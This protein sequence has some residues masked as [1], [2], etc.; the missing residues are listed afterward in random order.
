MVGLLPL[1]AATSSRA[2]RREAYPRSDASASRWFLEARPELRRL[3][4]RPAQARAIAGRRL[5]SILDETKLRRV[6]ATMLDENEFLS[7]YGIRSLSRY[8]AEHPYRVPRRRARNTECRICRRSPTPACSAATRTGAG[9]S[10]CRST[11][12]IIRALL[13]Y[14]LYY[15]DDFTVECPTGSGRQM[16]LY[17]VAEE[18]ARRLASIFLQGPGRPT[19]GLRRQP[20]VPGRPA[21]ARSPAVLRVFPR[22]QRGRP[23]RQPPDRLDGDHRPQHA[24]LRQPHARAG[25]G[26]RQ[27]ILLRNPGPGA[28][29]GSGGRS[30]LTLTPSDQTQVTFPGRVRLPIN[31]VSGARNHAPC[32]ADR[33]RRTIG[34]PRIMGFDSHPRALANRLEE[35]G[36]TLLGCS[37]ESSCGAVPDHGRGRRSLRRGRLPARRAPSAGVA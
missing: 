4:P 35:R 11:P 2:T 15:G 28:N 9:R 1:C 37:I 7:P 23:R 33:P 27:T 16:T 24:S 3:H 21:L 22:R 14:Y 34:L 26:S 12:L 10:G 8:H 20:E 6:L 18:M 19:A 32:D 13:Q 29:R 25:S 36:W 17:Q 30:S 5:G 31:H